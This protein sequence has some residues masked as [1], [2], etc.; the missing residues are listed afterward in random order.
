MFSKI[1]AIHWPEALPRL[2]ADYVIVQLAYLFALA[3]SAL[4]ATQTQPWQTTVELTAKLRHLY[5]AQF[6][7]LSLLFPI[8]F[9][10]AGFYS[11]SR[12]YITRFKV[13]VL[14]RGSLGAALLYLAV[15][16]V[17]NRAETLPRTTLVGFFFLMGSGV[18]TARLIRGWLIR[19]ANPRAGE[20]GE[21]EEP[22]VLIVGGAGYI[23]SIL[24]RKLL[25]AGRRVRV[26]DSLVYGDAAIRELYDNPRFELVP[27][28]CRHI[29]SVVAALKGVRSVIHL[30]AIVGDPACEQNRQSALEINYAATRMLLEVARGNRVERF[31]FASSCSVYGATEHLMDEFSKVQ[32]ISLYAETKVD[33]EN[34]LLAARSE[35][36]HPTVLRFATVFGHS[37]RPRF[38]LV[39]NLLTAKA[40]KEGVITIYNGEQWRPFIHVAD[41]AD[42]ILAALRADTAVV[43]GEIFNVGDSRLNHTLSDIAEKIRKAFPNTRIECVENADRRNYRVSFDKIRNQLGFECTNSVDD[44]IAELRAAFQ[45]KYVVDHTDVQYHN[46]RFLGQNGSPANQERLDEFVMAAFARSN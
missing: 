17:V 38:D 18:V 6:L 42:G 43:S 33:S 28:D 44:G 10:A 30:A 19:E 35:S 3:L 15:H 37:P 34:A 16:F 24:C 40:H 32:P 12:T 39:V 41:V 31:I 25:D 14:L 7:P 5:F 2:C 13:E 21:A 11:Q 27:G 26:L 46:Q 23:G 9:L 45:N 1:S 4:I 29:Q 36:F 20:V 8:A 22:P